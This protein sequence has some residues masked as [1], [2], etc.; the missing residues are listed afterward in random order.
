MRGVILNGGLGNQLFQLA[1]AMHANP[2]LEIELVDNLGN[3]R[4]N[5]SNFPDIM[6]FSLPSDVRLSQVEFRVPRFRTLLKRALNLVLRFAVQK[7][8]L[9]LIV[10][11][12]PFRALSKIIVLKSINFSFGKGV[13]FS[14]KINSDELLVGYF[15]S[16]KYLSNNVYKK[17]MEIKPI[18]ESL[19][20]QTLR[21]LAREKR[22]IMVHLRLGDYVKNGSYGI[23]GESY[24]LEGIRRCK[25]QFPL[26]P[27]WLFTNEKKL[28]AE[29]FSLD[30]QGEINLFPDISE[31]ANENLELF[32]YGAA[33]VIGNSTFSWWGCAL[34]YDT[35][36][37]VFY[38]SPWYQGMSDPLDLTH[39][40]W[41]P[42]NANFDL[43]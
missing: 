23:P 9:S 26:S 37:P 42:L 21:N 27:V 39:P 43:S 19:E 20:L 29:I 13:G 24:Y 31:S 38:P 40:D 28:V 4:R 32:R 15:Q 5:S 3:P 25:S 14:E 16:Y 22:P 12:M 41:K 7:R 11:L 17:L 2:N 18:Q 1:A 30:L 33:Y 10:A 8:Q 6:G 35:S 34:R 36:A